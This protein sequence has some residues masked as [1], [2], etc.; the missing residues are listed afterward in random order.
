MKITKEGYYNSPAPSLDLTEKVSINTI[1]QARAGKSDDTQ[2]F[3]FGIPTSCAGGVIGKGG[4]ILKDLQAEFRV[5]VHV[6]RE[7]YHGERLVVLSSLNGADALP[8][9]DD[10]RSALNRCAAKIK[11]MVEQL[12]IAQEAGVKELTEAPL[13]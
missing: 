7:E 9:D 10:K 11:G 6:E 12:E 4:S 13:T 2:E 8:N 5:R 1:I 3:C